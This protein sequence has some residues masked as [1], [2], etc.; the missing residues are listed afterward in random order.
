MRSLAVATAALLLLAGAGLAGWSALAGQAS[1]S[2]EVWHSRG[3]S[4][5]AA[6]VTIGDDECTWLD[7]WVD[8]GSW[9]VQMP[10]GKPTEGS[11]LVVGIE[12][13][14]TCPREGVVGRLDDLDTRGRWT[15]AGGVNTWGQTDRPADAELIESFWGWTDAAD[16]DITEGHASADGVVTV[17]DVTFAEVCADID[18]SVDWDAAGGV[19][20]SGWHGHDPL[21]NSHNLFGLREATAS[22]T[23]RP[24]LVGVELNLNLIPDPAVYA[25]VGVWQNGAVCKA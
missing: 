24:V 3:A 11:G 2:A 22:G 8:A 14:S 23:M 18:V 1:A 7:T 10:P 12:V 6:F 5:D 21:C 16:V 9:V 15:D 4:A 17:C 25:S 19:G 13:W 20:R